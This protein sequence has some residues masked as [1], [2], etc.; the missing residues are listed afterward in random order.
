MRCIMFWRKI[1]VHFAYDLSETL[2]RTDIKGYKLTNLIEAIS[3]K[4][5]IQ[6]VDWYSW[7][8]LASSTLRIKTNWHSHLIYLK[9]LGFI[10]EESSRE[11]EYRRVSLLKN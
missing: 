1:C 11:V 6:A 3:R 7:E 8:F 9:V 5:N 2:Q 10:I 4:A